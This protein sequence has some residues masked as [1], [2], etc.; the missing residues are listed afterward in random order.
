ML[1]FVFGLVGETSV[2]CTSTS[3]L[4]LSLGPSGVQIHSQSSESPHISSSNWP[5]S[6]D[7]PQSIPEA[8]L[9]FCKTFLIHSLLPVL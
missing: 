9:Q 1:I 7:L 4:E 2:S 3:R 6:L 5:R 8:V